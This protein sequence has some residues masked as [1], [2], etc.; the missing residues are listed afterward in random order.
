MSTAQLVSV[1]E[2]LHSTIEP[3]AEYVEGRIVPRSVP[4]KSHSKWQGRLNRTLYE[5]GHPMGYEVW[6]EQHI[7]TRSGPVRY[8]VPDI[9]VTLGEPEE[10]IFTEP[11]FLCIEILSPDDS[12]LELRAKIGEYLALG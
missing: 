8:R 3:A 10:E 1:E 11:P 6:V 2:Y 12:A 5:I 7:R 4:R 9:C